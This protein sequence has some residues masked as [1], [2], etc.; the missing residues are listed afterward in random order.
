MFSDPA[1]INN[2]EL[3]TAGINKSRASRSPQSRA[4][5]Y[6]ELSPDCCANCRKYV[7]RITYAALH[8]MP[9]ITPTSIR[10]MPDMR[11]V[12]PNVTDQP[13]G[14]SEDGVSDAD[15]SSDDGRLPALRCGRWLAFFSRRAKPMSSRVT[16][17]EK[18]QTAKRRPPSHALP[19]SFGQKIFRT[20]NS[21]GKKSTE[22]NIPLSPLVSL[23]P[24][25]AKTVVTTDNAAPPAS[26]GQDGS[27]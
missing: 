10:A 5:T 23:F 26:S 13:R 27:A 16:A 24:V 1:T 21:T 14:P 8:Q 19:P 18:M 4:I 9:D 11:M 22:A 25:R 6:V 7:F 3:E 15:E 20:V 12:L 17:S 2:M